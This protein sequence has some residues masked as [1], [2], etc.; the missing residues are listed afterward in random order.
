[1]KEYFSLIVSSAV[2]SGIAECISPDS[3]KKYLNIITGIL[4]ISVILSPIPQIR[5]AELF[6]DLD[7][8]IVYGD[9]V[10]KDAIH[11]QLEKKISKDATE[12][13]YNEIGES[14]TVE[15]VIEVTD[16]GEISGVKE[17]LVW[18]TEKNTE[19]SKILESAYSPSK[20]TFLHRKKF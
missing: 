4:M 16:E 18:T 13:I 11:S 10:F 9:K 14:V 6:S 15:A 8:S 1:M 3:W 20:I 2:L 7:V 12:R 17:L 19:I 5:K